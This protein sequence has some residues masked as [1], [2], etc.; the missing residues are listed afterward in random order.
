MSDTTDIIEH[1]VYRT[2]EAIRDLNRISFGWSQINSEPYLWAR[3]AYN[4]SALDAY[5]WSAFAQE[6]MR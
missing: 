4:T 1:G 5:R 2:V 3:Q 6:E